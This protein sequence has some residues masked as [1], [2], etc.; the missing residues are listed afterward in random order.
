[1]RLTTFPAFT[2]GAICSSTDDQ[3]Y[4]G[5]AP[6]PR[7]TFFHCTKTLAPH[8]VGT[9]SSLL[10]L[11]FTL[12]PGNSSTNNPCGAF[13]TSTVDNASV[14]LGSEE[15]LSFFAPRCS[16]HAVEGAT[17][18][19]SAPT[20]SVAALVLKDAMP[21]RNTPLS[22]EIGRIERSRRLCDHWYFDFDRT[23]CSIVSTFIRFSLVISWSPIFTR[24]VSSRNDTSRKML[25]ES[26]MPLSSRGS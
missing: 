2:H 11:S 13:G 24:N 7:S 6:G 10:V 19:K 3:S 4:C 22:L 15:P 26:R 14:H 25:S 12:A 8:T 17:E 18:A 1:M 20:S 23:N 16:H 21:P 9:W 5:F